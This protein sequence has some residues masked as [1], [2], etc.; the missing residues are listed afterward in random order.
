MLSLPYGPT[1]TF[2]HDYWKSHSFARWTLVGKVMSLPFN[3]LSRFVIA[4]LPMSKHPVI[5]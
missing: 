1:F 3:M 2:I 5:A 4:F